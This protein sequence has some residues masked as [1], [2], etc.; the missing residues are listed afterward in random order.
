LALLELFWKRTAARQFK[1]IQEVQG[2]RWDSLKNDLLLG[3]TFALAACVR[4]LSDIWPDA[5]SFND[6]KDQRR[7]G[8]RRVKQILDLSSVVPATRVISSLMKSP[9]SRRQPAV[10]SQM[11]GLAEKI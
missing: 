10:D 11:Q 4:V 3:V 9:V 2:P 6:T 7:Y 5:K 8:G 1:R